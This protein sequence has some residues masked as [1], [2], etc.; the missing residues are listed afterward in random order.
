M[1]PTEYVTHYNEKL[2]KQKEDEKA[3]RE[4]ILQESVDKAASSERK[5]AL[6]F[7][8]LEEKKRTD[9]LLAKKKEDKEFT[10][11][12]NMGKTLKNWKEYEYY[13]PGKWDKP[14]V[15]DKEMWTCCASEVKE[16]R[17]CQ[18]R[19]RDKMAWQFST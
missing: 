7:R 13:H 14:R 11:K 16:S 15:Q 18:F 3:Q 1:R 17:G 5:A 8:Y 4:K 10:G 12:P 6:V 19:V 2:R 9:A